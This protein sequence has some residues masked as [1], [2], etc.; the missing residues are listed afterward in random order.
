MTRDQLQTFFAQPY[1]RAAWL[2][3]IHGVF[4]H[5]D[6]ANYLWI[7]L[8]HSALRNP[9]KESGRGSAGFAMANSA[10]D[11]RTSEVQTVME[12]RRCSHTKLNS[13]RRARQ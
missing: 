1:D 11:A 3:T 6:N 4:P 8:F 13:L 10:A 2:N 9:D 12:G 7:Q 5:T